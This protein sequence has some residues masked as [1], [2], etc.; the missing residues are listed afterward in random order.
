L[1]SEKAKEKEKRSSN[2]ISDSVASTLHS[3]YDLF[4]H[5]VLSF[6]SVIISVDSH[7]ILEVGDFA[8]TSVAGLL[9]V[10]DTELG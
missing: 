10:G 6:F 1:K 3:Y 5:V 8:F 9:A 7:T 2:K 4:S